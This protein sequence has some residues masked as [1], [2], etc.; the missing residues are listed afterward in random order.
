MQ[1]IQTI[2]SFI[3]NATIYELNEKIILK[4]IE[5]RQ[6]HKIEIPDA[7]IA[8]TALVNKHA[9]I[10]HNISDYRNIAG[11]KIIDLRQIKDI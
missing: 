3:G 2:N 11:L 7:I 9:L 8:A 1:H 6:K 10:T 5:I 4:T